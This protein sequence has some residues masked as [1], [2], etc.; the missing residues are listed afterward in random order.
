MSIRKL[1]AARGALAGAV[2]AGLWLSDAVSQQ[3]TIHIPHTP[4]CA[5]S[6]GETGGETGT[7]QFCTSKPG[8][9]A[10]HA[11]QDSNSGA[12]VSGLGKVGVEG[13]GAIGVKGSALGDHDVG[14]AF[15]SFLGDII[16]GFGGNP[17]Q[18]VFRIDHDGTLFV[19]GQPVGQKG[20]KGD[21]GDKGL[22]GDQGLQGPPGPPTK[23]VAIC[24][25]I[26]P[27]TVGNVSCPCQHTVVPS[28]G[29]PCNLTSDTGSCSS[30][31][32]CCAVCAP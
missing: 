7:V 20:D 8:A 11:T 32:G 23:T 9:A 17:E 13:Q 3:P 22:K 4:P 29:A 6:G 31:T 30:Q 28:V 10:I 27:G 2:L 1:G 15:A 18:L 12:A 21:K 16:Q 25:E 19:R 14:G 24:R 5:F 26:P